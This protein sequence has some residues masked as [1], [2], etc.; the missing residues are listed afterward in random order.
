MWT[1]RERHEPVLQRARESF[2]FAVQRRYVAG[3]NHPINGSLPQLNYRRIRWTDYIARCTAVIWT[4]R[5]RRRLPGMRQS[6]L[7]NSKAVYQIMHSHWTKWQTVPS[8]DSGMNFKIQDP[9]AR[10]I[11][12]H[13]YQ[14]V[15]PISLFFAFRSF[16]T[17]NVGYYFF[18]VFIKYTV[19]LWNMC[20]TMRWLHFS[21]N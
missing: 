8:A 11:R 12:A 6:T 21:S 1:K 13:S 5:S 17:N 18:S 4:V 9:Y 3:W 16:I 10:E 20:Y 15:S 2:S 14:W 19:I 7:L